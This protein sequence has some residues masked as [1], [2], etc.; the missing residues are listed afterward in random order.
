MK[1]TLPALAAILVLGTALPA[2][3]D[4]NEVGHVDVRFRG[5]RATQDVRLGGPVEKLQFKAE[6][7]DVFCRS[8]RASFANGRD[9]EIFRGEIRRGNSRDI[10][11]PGDRRDL[12]NLSFRC[13]S[14]H[15]GDAS[16]RV[17]AD[18][19]RYRDDWRRN[20]DFDRLWARTFNVGSNLVNDWQFIGAEDFRGRGESETRFAGWRGR[21]I[22]SLA[23]KPVG[24]D[25]R[26]SRVTAQFRNG[27][28]QP[29]DVDRGDV[30]REGQYYKI[31]VPGDR[32]NLESISLSCRPMNGRQVTMQIF[33]SK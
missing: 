22:D 21:N 25:A 6:G 27:R 8:V 2:F 9:R 12:R 18:V 29:L 7:S 33:T 1:T 14:Q 20:P 4:W 13:A 3:A 11:L 28:T 5:D 23:L 16:I 24:A 10:D 32:R 26:C 19:G 31:D 17:V 30:M 15:R